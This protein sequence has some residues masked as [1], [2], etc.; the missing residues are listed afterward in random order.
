M[1]ELDEL[2]K[3]P[4]YV[5]STRNHGEASDFVGIL[6]SPVTL[7]APRVA[8]EV[9]AVGLPESRVLLVLE[10]DAT[11]PLRALPEIEVRD[12]QSRGTAVLRM[13][14]LAVELVCDPRLA[15]HDV[16]EWQVFRVAAVAESRDVLG[17]GVHAFHQRVER[18]ALPRGVEL[19]PLRHAM[20][21][22]G[23]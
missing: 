7:L 10:P 19:R 3:L 11:H 9:V 22:F 16:L 4:R 15:V 14:W 5:G 8:I 6:V 13:E 17:R 1:D 21:V 23:D 18:H 12:E 2:S 20:D